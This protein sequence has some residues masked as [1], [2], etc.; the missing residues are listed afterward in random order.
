[1]TGTRRVVV[2]AALPGRLSQ[3]LAGLQV[4][5]PGR[6]EPD[7][8]GPMLG[9]ALADA[10]ALLP[11]LSVQVDE[12][13]FAA[14]PRLR[15]VA[16]YAVGYDN[17]D[18]AAATRRGVVVTNTPGV[19]T[20]AT[21]DLTLAL[22]LA[23]ARRVPEGLDLARSGRWAG[24]RPE[25]L[26]GRDLHGAR[27]G[28]LGL[29]RIGR[30]VAARARAFG[31]EV[32]YAQPRAVPAEVAEGA[33]HVPLAELLAD[34]D[35]V[36]LHCPLDATT[37]HLIDDAAISCMK[38]TAILI[39]TARGPIVD[40]EALADALDTGRLFAAGLDVYERE[41]LISERLRRHPRAVVLPHLGSA[42]LGARSRMAE[43]A[44]QSIADLLGGQRPA[45]VVNPEVLADGSYGARR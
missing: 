11:L 38:P 17:V 41:P 35:F 18:V 37:R 13:L 19:L 23:A 14:A 4:T 5:M 34:S 1:M 28:L 40:E 24:W 3:I 42:T 20:E 29:G 10:D 31:L 16:N 36:S 45:H 2:T 26:L 12:A 39:N 33:R 30:A 44:A 7:L 27:L 8:T 21:A 15:I 43:T 32:T 9:A 25:E 6:G 22:L